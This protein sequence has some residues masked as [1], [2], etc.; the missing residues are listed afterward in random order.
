M[1]EAN[2]NATPDK[3]QGYWL[4]CARPIT[5]ATPHAHQIVLLLRRARRDTLG[6]RAQCLTRLIDA[7][8]SVCR[9][10]EQLGRVE[11]KVTQ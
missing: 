8:Q 9:A 10:I 4:H 11:A 6:R 3:S 5:A 2:P 7:Q 1:Y